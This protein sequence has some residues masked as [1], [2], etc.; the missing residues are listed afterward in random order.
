MKLLIGRVR[1]RIEGVFHEIQNTGRNPGRLLNKSVQG[2]ITHIAAKITS[3]TL[4]LSAP[5]S[6]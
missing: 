6:I 4:R 3:H 2:F 5:Q 1:P